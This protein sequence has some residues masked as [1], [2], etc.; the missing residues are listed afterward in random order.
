MFPGPFVTGAIV[1]SPPKITT[2]WYNPQTTFLPPPTTTITANLTAASLIAARTGYCP[3]SPDDYGRGV[4]EADL[5]AAC[6]ALVEPYC[7]PNPDAPIPTSTRFLANCTPVQPL[8]TSTTANLNA[9]PSPL[10]PN[11]VASCKQYYQV[12]GGDN[13]YGIANSFG[14]SLDQVTP[15][16][17][18]LCRLSPP[19]ANA[20]VQFNAWNPYVGA[21]CAK[22]FLGY[23]VCIKA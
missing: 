9:V 22:L 19:P 17:P 18:R 4:S 12:I 13:C 14:I 15:T 10:E 23:Y 20:S 1:A 21:D 5:P 16:S 6:Q 8:A 2:S 3:I 11:T 7:Y